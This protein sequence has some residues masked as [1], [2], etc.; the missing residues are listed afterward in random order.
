MGASKKY[1]EELREREKQNEKLK[2]KK[3]ERIRFRE[4]GK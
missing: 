2:Q 1:F 4:S 3:N